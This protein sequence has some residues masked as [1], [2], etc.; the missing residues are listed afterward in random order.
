MEAGLKKI[1]QSTKRSWTQQLFQP[2]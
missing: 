1:V 2:T